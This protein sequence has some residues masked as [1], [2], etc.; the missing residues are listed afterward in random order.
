MCDDGQRSEEDVGQHLGQDVRQVRARF[1][2]EVGQDLGRVYAGHVQHMKCVLSVR[3]T[4]VPMTGFTCSR[5]VQSL[6]SIVLWGFYGRSDGFH[7]FRTDSTF[8]MSDF[9]Q[10]VDGF[11][12]FHI[13]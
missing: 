9:P 4:R 13:L 6:G 10:G 12:G 5:C 11:H 8:A 2:Q 1:E 3:V 7:G